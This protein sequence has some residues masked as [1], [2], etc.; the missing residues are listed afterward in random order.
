MI[1]E[2]E[3]D[4]ELNNTPDL[5]L[6]ELG[7]PEGDFNAQPAPVPEGQKY[8]VALGLGR[9]GISEPTY[10]VKVNGEP[11]GERKRFYTLDL[12]GRFI[13]SEDETI[14]LAFFQGVASVKDRE[15]NNLSSFVPKGKTISGL[16]FIAKL[17]GLSKSDF[18]VTKELAIAIERILRM[19]VKPQVL[20]SKIQWQWYSKEMPWKKD[21]VDKKGKVVQ[22]G[23][24]KAEKLSDGSFNPLLKFTLPNGQVEEIT[25]RAVIVELEPPNVV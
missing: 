19:P 17:I 3:V 12:L 24:N 2:N 18:G 4:N 15:G 22:F 23:M 20:A 9:N 21:G 10:P 13:S 1:A 5:D 6:A 14:D 16:L 8:I 11:T 7:D 25:A